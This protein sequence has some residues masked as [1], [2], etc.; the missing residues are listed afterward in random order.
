MSERWS[1]VDYRVLGDGTSDLG[2]SE[3]ST[4]IEERDSKRV[5]QEIIDLTAL[6]DEEE[7][8][9][10][11][12]VVTPF[13]LM[14]SSIYDGGINSPHFITLEEI[15][16]SKSLKSCVLFSYQ[17]G[18]DFL[19][20]QFHTSVE[21]IT[22]IGQRGTIT[23]ITS[24]RALE[25]VK[26]LDIVEIFMPPYTCHH[27]KMIV[28]F[29][30]DD[31]C[32]IY[33]P[34]NNFTYEE[35]NLPQQVCWCSPVLQR[36]NG[37][38]SRNSSKFQ[39]NLIDYLASYENNLINRRL[40]PVIKK[41]NFEPL[42]N[43][44]FIYSTPSKKFASGFQ[45]LADSLPR[46]TG[47][48]EGDALKHYLCQSSTIGSAISKKTHG[49]LFT[50]VFIPY[51]EEIMTKSSKPLQ[52]DTVLQEFNKRRIKPYILYPTV[53][54]IQ[55]SPAGWLSSG[56]FHF[57]RL[58][59]VVHYDNLLKKLDAFYKQNPNDLSRERKATPCHSKFY[60]KSTTT[61]GEEKQNS[62]FDNLDWCIYTSSNLSLS[63]W[64]NLNGLP[65]NYEVGV[66]FVSDQNSLQC[67]SFNDVIY[68]RYRLKSRE[69]KQ[70]SVAP[71]TVI[72]VPF[73][74]PPTKYDI[75]KGDEA[76][77]MSKNY[78]LVDINGRAYET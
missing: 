56:W 15:L 7:K 65:R 13:R 14:R 27:S 43:V 46:K 49:N 64:G 1:K 18:M 2:E 4:D 71:S 40:I 45:L 10:G 9:E 77:C 36:S 37:M 19:L 57:N 33:M 67:Q 63:A 48:D 31:S 12:A 25:F 35:T 8:S 11:S 23:P 78:D 17:F 54:E 70:P 68:N 53:Q 39:D 62:Q 6:D 66:L 69:L 16:S 51:L 74:L 61:N 24:G 75:E 50:H 5:R 42:K 76:F 59:D 26:K 21:K 28:S 3:C 41:L 55:N 44:Q 58:K 30:K 29:F 60:F 20:E 22:I 52:T 72:M 34:S 38:Y 73:G 32:K 47:T